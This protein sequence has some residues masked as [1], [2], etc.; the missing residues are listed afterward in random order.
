MN[1]RV[2]KSLFF[3]LVL[4][5]LLTP[6]IRSGIALTLGLLYGIFIGNLFLSQTKKWTPKLLSYAIIGLGAGMNLEIALKVGLSGFVATALGISLTLIV[7]FILGKL[8]KQSTHVSMLLS[9]GTAICGGSAIAS[10]APVIQAKQEEISVSLGI[11]FLLNALALFI[12]PPVGHFLEL[13]QSQFA[14]WAAMAIHDTSSVVG[15]TLA[16]GHEA[17]QLGTTIKLA[18]ALWIVPVTLLV[19]T[20]WG[21]FSRHTREGVDVPPRTYPWFILG[22]LLMA[23]IYTWVPALKELS[24]GI[25]NIAKRIMILTL[26]LIGANINLA[27]LKSMGLKPVVQ[28]VILWL[29]ALSLTLAAVMTSVV[30]M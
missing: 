28:G 13:S 20:L 15:A 26:F 5:V 27:M 30:S 1:P 4:L 12:F 8:L 3:I 2:Q 16:Y 17:L 24:Q 7:G 21:R 10:V 29:L 14:F 25:E 9:V 22:F 19:G 6:A 11:V 23:A 18:R